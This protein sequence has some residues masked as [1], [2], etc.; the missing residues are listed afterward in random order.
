MTLELSTPRI[1]FQKENSKNGFTTEASYKMIVTIVVKNICSFRN[2]NI[3]SFRNKNNR[4][5]LG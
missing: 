3:C 5:G 1:L 4:G 2:K